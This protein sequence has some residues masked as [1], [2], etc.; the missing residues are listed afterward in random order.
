MLD[1]SKIGIIKK[2]V[3]ESYNKLFIGGLPHEMDDE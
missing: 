1:L 3:E 2:E